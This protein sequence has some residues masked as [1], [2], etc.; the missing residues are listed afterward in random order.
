MNSGIEV[1][2]F[3]WCLYIILFGLWGSSILYVINKNKLGILSLFT[4]FFGLFLVGFGISII[5]RFLQITFDSFTFGNQTDRLF[6]ISSEDINYALTILILYL[7]CVFFG[8]II[9]NSFKFEL[10][11]IEFM[12]EYK[13]HSIVALSVL[14]TFSIL[15]SSSLFPL[16]L[17]L[18]TP[19]GLLGS[20]WVI[21][22]SFS[23]WVRWK[24]DIKSLTRWL[25]LL[26]GF[27]N[28]A[29]SPYRENLAVPFLVILISGLF[30]GKRFKI[31]HISS[32]MVGIL[33]AS[34]LIIS[35]YRLYLWDKFSFE[36]IFSVLQSVDEDNFFHHSSLLITSL[37]RFHALDSTLLTVALVPKSIPFDGRD[38]IFDPFIRGFIPRI[39]FNDKSDN[40]RG[41]IFGMTIWTDV[42]SEASGARISPSMPGDLYSSNGIFPV[43]YGGLC[44]GILLATMN[45]FSKFHFSSKARAGFTMLF[46][47]QT[48]ASIER[49]Y[50]HMIAS[51][52]QMLLVICLLSYFFRS[53]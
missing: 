35:S 50:V 26:P 20:C 30:A 44:W 22:A 6:T 8:S 2:I 39:F 19:I 33:I 48:F 13:K 29:L 51:T 11:P 34:T 3:G 10:K 24:Y 49:D 1:N 27:L 21:P 43:I 12:G 14:S 46:A 4:S 36:D 32:Y 25:F 38:I 37:N 42:Y 9:V 40:D 17:P 16:P 18:L 15:L 28:A 52:I 45:R 53:E 31:F 41:V 5:F 23:W 47:T 7:T